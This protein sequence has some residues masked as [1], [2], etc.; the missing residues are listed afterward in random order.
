MKYSNNQIYHIYNQGNNKRKVF[1]S[2][3]NYEYFLFKLRGMITPFGDLVAYCLM[4][5]HYHLLFF[6]RSK[7]ITKEEYYNSVFIAESKRR[8]YKF[9]SKAIPV[10][11]KVLTKSKSEETI[12][13]NTALG[14]LQKSYTRAINNEKNWSG[15]LFRARL[16]AKDGQIHDFV[17]MEVENGKEKFDFSNRYAANCLRYIHHNPVEAGLVRRPED[18]EWSSAKEYKG[19]RKGTLCNLEIGKALIA[20]GE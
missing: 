7:E 10:Q 1:H 6:I 18:Y 20:I 13:I 8:K 2:R 17:S 15:S 3:E 5:N 12:T 4:P 16:K 11:K 19:L 14:Q 9:G